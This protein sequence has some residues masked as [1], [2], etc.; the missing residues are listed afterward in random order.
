MSS[1]RASTIILICAL[2][3]VVESAVLISDI[4]MHRMIELNSK[5]PFCKSHVDRGDIQRMLLASDQRRVRY[6]PLEVIEALEKECKEV[7]GLQPEIQGGLAFI[8]PGT[9]WCGP[10][11]IATEYSDVGRYAEEDRCCREHDLCPNQLSPGECKRGLCNQQPFTRSHC[12]CDIKFRRCLQ[13]LNTETANTLGA[14]FFNVVQ[15][16][17]FKERRPCSTH[18]RVG[19][20][21]TKVDEMCSQWKYRPSEKYIPSIQYK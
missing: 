7:G 21:K 14:V 8:Y 17:C 18:Q 9:K 15:V 4:G 11:S 20:N 3:V 1:L 19:Y 13:Q 5:R 2:C 12:D 10:G 6:V 16:T